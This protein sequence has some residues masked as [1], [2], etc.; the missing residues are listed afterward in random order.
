MVKT[1]RRSPGKNRSKAIARW[2]F[3]GF[4]EA[5]ATFSTRLL[6]DKSL[7]I[8]ICLPNARA[9]SQDTLHRLE[10]AGLP[11]SVAPDGISRSD[12]VLSLV[13]PAAALEAATAVAPHL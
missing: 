6:H 13:T 7:D 11:A 3:L 10:K 2:T 12:V 8:T 4:G 9:P 1:L 5:A